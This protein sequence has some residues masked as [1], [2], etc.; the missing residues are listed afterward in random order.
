MKRLILWDIDGTLLSAGPVARAAFDAA[1]EAVLGG[2]PGE[3]GVQMSGKT[4]PQ[5]ALEILARLAVSDEEAR[6]HLPAVLQA[7]EG[8]LEAAVD[9]IRTDGSVLPGVPEVLG[10]LAEEPGVLQ[11]VLTGNLAANA[12]L[13]LGA[14]GLDRLLDLDIGAYGSDHHD[15]SQLVPIAVGNVRGRRGLELGP[16]DAWVVGDTPADLACA[17]AGGARCLLVAT[18]RIPHPDLV[19]L[20]ADAVLVD[21]SDADR[22]VGLLLG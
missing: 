8:E 6:R 18:G 9:L 10:L 17:R 11:T 7:L 19:D 16:E 14:F 21:L 3:H 13:K 12:R 20:G 4:D 5:I 2:P 15:R 1:V 22:V